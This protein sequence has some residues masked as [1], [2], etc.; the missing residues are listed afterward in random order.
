MPVSQHLGCRVYDATEGGAVHYCR[1]SELVFRD[2]IVTQ[3]EYMDIISNILLQFN[4]S[5][6]RDFGGKKQTTFSID[7][8]SMKYSHFR[9]KFD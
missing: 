7:N 4:P 6:P 5:W 3:F 1:N 9:L 8:K 2:G